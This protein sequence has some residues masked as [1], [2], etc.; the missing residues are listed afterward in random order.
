QNGGIPAQ[1]QGNREGQRS[2][3]TKSDGMWSFPPPTRSP[4]AQTAL[5][6]APDERTPVALAPCLSS[7]WSPPAPA[8]GHS[9]DARGPSILSVH[10]T[11]RVH[12]RV[13]GAIVSLRSTSCRS[14]PRHPVVLPR[15]GTRPQ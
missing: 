8:V 10:D 11:Y 7:R 9:A 14:G 3:T 2:L 5:H 6:S 4:W 12:S 1:F 13:Q 15:A